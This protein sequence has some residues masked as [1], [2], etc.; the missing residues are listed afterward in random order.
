M[1]KIRRLDRTPDPL[2]PQQPPPPP[3][4]G[5]THVVQL[6]RTYPNLR[7]ARD[8]PFAPGGERSVALGYAKAAKRSRRLI[9]VEDQYFWGNEIA[10]TFLDSLRRQPRAAPGVRAAAVPRPG[11]LHPHPAAARPAAGHPG[12]DG[13]GA[14][15]GGGVRPGERRRHPGLRARQALRDG[16]RVVHD[17]VGQL[18]PPLLDPRLRADRRVVDR[19]DGSTSPYAQMLRLRLAAEHLGRLDRVLAGEDLADVVADCLEPEDMY[20]AYADERRRPGRLAHPAA[21]ADRAH[22]ASCAGS[23]SRTWPGRPGCGPASRCASCRTPTG[24][25]GG[26][27]SGAASDPPTD[28]LRSGP[29]SAAGLRVRLRP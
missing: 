11:G 13:G 12:P 29:R 16:R 24:G 21:G 18:Q 28:S 6:L 7:Q 5:G 17:R 3:V 25:R 9:Y 14:G 15:T 19:A 22:P 26:C 10:S 1:D 4:E 8:Y 2:P 23:T 27:G 20:A